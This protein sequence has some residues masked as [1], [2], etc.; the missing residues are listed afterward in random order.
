MFMVSVMFTG[1]WLGRADCVLLA[2][3]GLVW[4]RK[5]CST[6]CLAGGVYCVV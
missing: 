2:A 1:E 6:Q 4:S 3:F 5:A